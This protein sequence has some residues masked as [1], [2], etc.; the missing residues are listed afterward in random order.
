MTD[1]NHNPHLRVFHGGD[2][3]SQAASHRAPTGSAGSFE[4][5]SPPQL[6]RTAG[7]ARR[8]WPLSILYRDIFK[9]T[10]IVGV[11]DNLTLAD[12]ER[13]VQWWIVLTGDPPLADITRATCQAFLAALQRQ[14]GRRK[15]AD[16]EAEPMATRTVRKHG[17]NI[18]RILELAGPWSR[19]CPDGLDILDRV[20]FC[21]L[22]SAPHDP[23]SGDYSLEQMHAM[24]SAASRMEAP[25]YTVDPTPW[26][27][28][29]LVVGY[30]T[31]MRRGMLLRLQRSWID[32]RLE[33]V[34]GCWITERS[35]DGAKKGR[36][37]RLFL[38]PEALAH[39][40]RLGDGDSV[41]GARNTRNVVTRFGTLHRRAGVT[42]GA[43][44]Q[45]L[46]QTQLTQLAVL[47]LEREGMERARD[48][49]GHSTAAV[50]AQHYVSLSAQEANQ[51]RA[52]LA[53][54]SPVPPAAP[55]ARQRTLF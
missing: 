42:G 11:L 37:R 7:D 2:D 55:D 33:K 19:E 13:A 28:T 39:I 4:G 38:H 16:G 54:P 23:P 34:A 36:G 49:A 43:H 17:A 18:N 22:P 26:W 45:R 8:R 35:R 29:L 41:F 25:T 31:G 51:R 10:R 46:R 1:P 47:D 53:M 27:R 20:P 3:A 21:L 40:D 32:R 44:F 14:P 48:A 52:I 50:T 15:N 30:Y 6:H 12:Y 24:Y 5:T 9:P